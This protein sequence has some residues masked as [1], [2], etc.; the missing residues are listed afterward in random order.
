MALLRRLGATYRAQLAAFTESYAQK[1][2]AEFM[3]AFRDREGAD[4]GSKRNQ[5]SSGRKRRRLPG[6][7]CSDDNDAVDDGDEAEA[8]LE[9]ALDAMLDA[10]GMADD[11]LYD[12]FDDFA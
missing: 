8:A 9:D 5:Y 6:T 12:D 2:A 1:T 3:A 7:K 4:T 11:N 10:Q